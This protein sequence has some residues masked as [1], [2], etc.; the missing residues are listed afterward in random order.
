VALV[1][2]KESTITKVVNSR[3]KYQMQH[4]EFIREDFGRRRGRGSGFAWSDHL[5]QMHDTGS[6]LEAMAVRG[7]LQ[8]PR[9]DLILVDDPEIDPKLQKVDPELVEKYEALLTNVMLPMLDEGGSSFYWIGTLLSRQCF[10]YYVVTTTTDERFLYWNRR[11]LDAE[12][13]GRGNLLWEDKWDWLAA[14]NAQ[15]R[16]RPGEG[17]EQVLQMRDPVGFYEMERDELWGK[18]PL[19]SKGR[20]RSWIEGSDGKDK[21]VERGAGPVVS[22]MF[23]VLTMDWARCL[24]PASDYIAMA[25]VGVE[26]QKPFKNVWWI[27]D[28]FVARLSGN[29]WVPK[30]WELAMKWRVQYAGVEAV[31]AQE[32]LVH[33]AREYVE[34]NNTIGW[35]PR[36]VPIKY[37]SGLS[38]EDRIGGLEWRF[39]GGKIKYP[40]DLAREW[41]WRELLHEIEGFNGSP[42]GTQYDDAI[43]TVAM[44][45]FLVRGSR[46]EAE[47]APTVQDWD[48][49]AHLMAGEPVVDGIQ[50]GLAV[51]PQELSAEDIVKLHSQ[52]YDEWEGSQ[53]PHR[54]RVSWIGSG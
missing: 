6:V 38:K 22:K 9:P 28:L 31:G 24:S 46:G 42:G 54:E 11:L 10:L 30:F 14:Y 18:N 20:I 45:Q 12:D 48:A 19:A 23:R 44:V 33:T 49:K 47:E 16:N 17:E 41:P 21:E 2:S 27:L 40:R 1:L 15:R 29:K 7:G 13:D 39:R 50:V 26:N 51:R 43:D 37:P 3:L 4:N 5:M 52:E 34:R 25:V 32:T 8:G 53:N 36:V 35:V